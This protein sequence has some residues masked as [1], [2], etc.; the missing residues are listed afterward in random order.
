MAPDQCLGNSVSLEQSLPRVAPKICGFT[1]C[2]TLPRKGRWRLQSP[3]AALPGS[4]GSS[5]AEAV[6]PRH[7]GHGSF[8]P[9]SSYGADWWPR[10][11]RLRFPDAQASSRSRGPQGRGAG[12]RGLRCSAAVCD[13]RSR[14]AASAPRD[15]AMVRAGA[16]GTHL[17]A[18]GL[19]IFGD[20]RKMNKRQ[21]MVA[22]S[23][24][25]PEVRCGSGESGF[26]EK[27]LHKGSCG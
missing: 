18:S 5:L 22:R 17:P 8:P 20:L 7:S 9:L 11:A 23:G 2:P 14:R 3:V 26:G 4:P 16:V 19:D 12:G 21:V 15:P 1:H 13:N 24:G 6:G 10:L 27:G 25:S